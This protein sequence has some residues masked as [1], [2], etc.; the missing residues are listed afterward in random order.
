MEIEQIRLLSP[1]SSLKV[2]HN[3]FQFVFTDYC[4]LLTEYCLTGGNFREQAQDIVFDH[5]GIGQ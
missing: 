2:S 5:A 1:F 4:S 3:L